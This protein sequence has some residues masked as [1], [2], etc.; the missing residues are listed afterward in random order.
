MNWPDFVGFALATNHFRDAVPPHDAAIVSVR[1]R[2]HLKLGE[3]YIPSAGAKL[4][5]ADPV[6]HFT[7]SSK[8]APRWMIASIRG[9]GERGRG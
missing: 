1:S 2:L 8:M 7:M 6:S 5:I 4:T 3:Q 9:S